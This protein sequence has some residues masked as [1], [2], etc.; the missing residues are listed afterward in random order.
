MVNPILT[1]LTLD[2]TTVWRFDVAGAITLHFAVTI[3]AGAAS[4]SFPHG[5]VPGRAGE[6]LELET[7]LLPASARLASAVESTKSGVDGAC[8]GF[9]T[10]LVSW[11][12][13]GCG[14]AAVA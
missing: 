4:R 2:S 5:H 6:R 14:F 11:Y 13:S 3:Q 8:V 12:G 1:S 9:G 7:F 10:E